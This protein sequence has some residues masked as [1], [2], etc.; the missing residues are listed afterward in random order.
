MQFKRFS[1]DT[2]LCSSDGDQESRALD[3]DTESVTPHRRE[4]PRL[5]QRQGNEGRGPLGP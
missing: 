5:V 1:L 2:A 3:A 4:G